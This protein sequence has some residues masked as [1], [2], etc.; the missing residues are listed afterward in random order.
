MKY[1]KLILSTVILSALACF[2]LISGCKKSSS[3]GTGSQG[4]L[5]ATIGDSTFTAKITIGAY[6]S[7]YD[8]FAVAGYTFNGSDTNALTIDLPIPVPVNLPF[9]T[10]TAFAGLSYSTNN[11][12][13]VYSAEGGVGHAVIEITY[14]DSV[15]NQI[16]GNFSG[17]LVQD[18]NQGDSIVITNGLFNTSFTVVN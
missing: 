7:T 14:F 12:L 9:N 6:S 11:G 2:I 10:D 5:T 16:T 3:S 17:V 4:T 1:K 13:Y 8:V 15:K 18:T